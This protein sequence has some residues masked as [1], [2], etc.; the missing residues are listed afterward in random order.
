[1]IEG[2]LSISRYYARILF[3]TDATHS[4]IFEQFSKVLHDELNLV[5]EN[6]DVPLLVHTPIGTLSISQD[7]PSVP[8]LVDWPRVTWSLLS[9]EDEGL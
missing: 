4:F 6:L 7:F 2:T 8:I 3:D 1:M 5:A 9:F